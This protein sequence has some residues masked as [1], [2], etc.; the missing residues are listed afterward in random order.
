MSGIILVSL[1]C[2]GVRY[3]VLPKIDA[4]RP[5]IERYLGDALDTQVSIGSI[6]A[7]WRGLHPLLRAKRVVIYERP[8]EPLLVLPDVSAVLGWR[9]VLRL[10]PRFAALTLKGLTLQARRDPDN[11]LWVAGQI[12]DLSETRE[13][14]RLRRNAVLQWLSSQGDISLVDG[15]LTW[16]DERRGAPAVTFT[17]VSLALRNG[18]RTHRFALQ[19]Q[20]PQALA[21]TLDVRGEFELEA[22]FFRALR[23]EAGDAS[24]RWHGRAYAALDGAIPDAWRPWVDVPSVKGRMAARAWA[25]FVDGRVGQVAFDAAAHHIDLGAPSAEQPVGVRF[26]QATMHAQGYASTL[27]SPDAWPVVKRPERERMAIRAQLKQALIDVPQAYPDRS[28]AVDEGALEGTLYRDATGQWQA[29]IGNAQL[30]NADAKLHMQ[31]QWTSGGKSP[32]GT[33]DLQGELTDGRLAAVHRYLP[34]VVNVDAREWLE[35]GLVAGAIPRATVVLKGDLLDFPFADAP[36]GGRFLLAGTVRDATIDYAPAEGDQPG[37]PRVENVAG[38]V[39]IEG[40]SLK[41]ETAPGAALT[42]GREP[43]VTLGAIHAAIPNLEHDAVLMLKGTTRGTV[44]AYI[45]LVQR[46]PLSELLDRSLDRAQGTGEMRLDLNLDLPLSHIADAR[47]AGEARFDNNT[48][49]FAPNVPAATQLTGPLR[50]DEQ[51]VS[52]DGLRAHFLGGPLTIVGELKRSGQ[53]LTFKGNATVAEASRLLDDPLTRRVTGGAAYSGRLTYGRGGVVDATIESDLVGVAIDLPAPVGKTAAA[54]RPVKV[55]WSGARDSGVKGR[56]W[57]DVIGGESL[58]ARVEW[59]PGADGTFLFTRGAVGVN[60]EVALPPAGIRANIAMPFLDL[61]AWRAVRDQRDERIA[62]RTPAKA[63]TAA[64]A[65]AAANAAAIGAPRTAPLWLDRADIDL[66]R[67]QASGQ[68]WNAVKASLTRPQTG[69][70]QADVDAKEV[71]GR[72]QWRSATASSPGVDAGREQWIVRLDRLILS[73]TETA[74]TSAD[75]ARDAPSDDDPPLD[76]PSMDVEI[77]ALTYVGMQLG[78][79]KVVGER[80][81]T[82]GGDD[83]WRLTQ[84]RIENEA[85]KLNATGTLQLRGA[86]RGLTTQANIDIADLGELLN[87]LGHADT[88][89]GG[90]GSVQARLTWHNLPWSYRAADVDGEVDVALDKGRFVHVTSRSARLLELLSLQSLERIATFKANPAD[91]VRDG[92]PFDT[93]RGHLRVANGNVSTDDYKIN[94]PVAAIVLAGSSNLVAKRWDVNALVVPNLDV[95]GAAV[96]AGLA[97]NPIIGIGAFLTQWVLQRPL[98]KAMAMQYRVSGP[99]DDPQVN[100][101]DTIT[102][103]P[104]DAAKAVRDHVEN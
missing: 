74:E 70:W 79:L 96:A 63:P 1:M 81:A 64:T 84:L 97:V 94:G 58:T 48:F 31:G 91:L 32:A 87:R 43:R 77:K 55:S 78:T 4:W 102:G 98:S 60:R 41:I 20:G 37:W 69:L 6:E 26:A 54:A 13:P 39:V 17:D 49:Q 16:L 45:H 28:L 5:D 18:F 9:S 90:S 68:R 73:E 83:R 99:W 53:N 2:L 76:I 30:A 27:L 80:D 38:K 67:L 66:E 103:G 71:K 10:E 40:Q 82:A 21:G 15:N 89:R 3:V 25:D 35:K 59:A 57:L 11:R 85:A 52:T 44:P 22:G 47:I 51:G 19:A 92:F 12:I 101:V 33:V 75:P 61:D 23:H 93:V 29:A 72:V 36:K 14:D 42:V 95:S 56:R 50:F 100:P 62:A 46:S 34:D 88:V 104:H 24:P 7:E 8:A 65:A 86:N